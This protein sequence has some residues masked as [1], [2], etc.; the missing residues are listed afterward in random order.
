MY[1]SPGHLAQP[2][3]ERWLVSLQLFNILAIIG[4]IPVYDRVFVPLLARFGKKMTLLQRIGAPPAALKL[5]LS[6]MSSEALQH[7]CLAA[8]CLAVCKTTA[9]PTSSGYQECAPICA[10][11]VHLLQLQLLIVP[12]MPLCRLGPGGVCAEHADGG[13]GGAPTAG[14][15]P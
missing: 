15:V 4:L 10:S 1:Y 8:A 6:R 11:C 9:Q 12:G 7:P 3:T 5:A 2:C 14:D 13:V